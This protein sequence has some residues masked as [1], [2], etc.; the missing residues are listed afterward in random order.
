MCPQTLMIR[1]EEPVS[2]QESLGGRYPP[3][4]TPRCIE[5]LHAP[6][7]LP[8]ETCGSEFSCDGRAEV[9]QYQV[10]PIACVIAGTIQGA[11]LIAIHKA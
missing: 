7:I 2:Y 8:W 1:C 10:R 5:S 11:K 9:K 4:C 6:A 3:W